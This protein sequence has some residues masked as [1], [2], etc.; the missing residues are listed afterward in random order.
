MLCG[1]NRD[2]SRASTLAQAS[3]LIVSIAPRPYAAS[4]M[5]GE[6][7]FDHCDS[8]ARVHRPDRVRRQH[9]GGS[10]S[11]LASMYRAR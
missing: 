11:R 7:R 10:S 4:A 3:T 6:G 9:I 1:A 2:A 5:R 8:V